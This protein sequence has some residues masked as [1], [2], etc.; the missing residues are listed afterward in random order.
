MTL[1]VALRWRAIVLT[2]V[3]A[4]DGE[5]VAVVLGVSVRSIHRWYNLFKS[6]GNVLP[7]K[8]EARGSRWPRECRPPLTIMLCSTLASTSRSFRMRS[9]C[10]STSTICRLLEFDL[11][12]NRKTLTKHARECVPSEIKN[13]YDK[14]AFIRT[15][16]AGL[17]RRNSE[18]RS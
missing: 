3:Y 6:N 11:G 16:T 7:L 18:S 2:Y 5:T 4:A 10:N 15:W 13:F 17:C 9:Q 1:S 14:E 12:L 8:R